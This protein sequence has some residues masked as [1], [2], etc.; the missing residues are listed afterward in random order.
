MGVRVIHKRYRNRALIIVTV[1]IGLLGFCLTG[2]PAW[3]KDR[4]LV[5]A[6]ILLPT[7]YDPAVGADVVSRA[8]L[9]AAYE[10]LIR[11]KPGTTVLEPCLAESYEVSPDSLTYTFTLKKN[12]KF[13][14]G[15]D[16]NAEAVK[17]SIDRLKE[18]NRGPAVYAE[19][20]KE[21]QVLAEDKV[22]LILKAINPMFPQ[23]LPLIYM[24][25][26]TYVK[27]HEENGDW[28]RK[29]LNENL[30]GGTGPY[31]M[32]NF[33]PGEYAILVKNPDYWRGWREKSIDRII[34]RAIKESTTRRLLM[35]K[36]DIHISNRVTVDDLVALEKKSD[37]QIVE[38]PN[39]ACQYIRLNNKK[40][41]FD[42]P[43]IR[44][45]VAYAFDYRAVIEKIMRGRATPLYGPMPK[46]LFAH[47][48]ALPTLNQ[49]K[50]KA[51]KIL[52]DAGYKPGDIQFT[53]MH[54]KEI[55]IA[56]TIGELLQSDLK[57]VGIEMKMQE[58]TWVALLGMIKSPE[59]TP[60]MFD[61]AHGDAPI[62]DSI[63]FLTKQFHSQSTGGK[64]W[65]QHW[66]MNPKVDE[67]LDQAKR[68]AD[69]TQRAG[70]IK[71]AQK[72]IFEDCPQVFMFQKHTMK[73]VHK[74]VKGY[75]LDPL[76]WGQFNFYDMYFE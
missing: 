67:L 23:R 7:S 27:Q 26:P 70:L 51:R 8:F 46:G 64:S 38:A 54:L 58:I 32:E 25:S 75:Q 12:I 50:E 10:G 68:T 71:E 36:G 37:I 41:P 43:R 60:Q 5:V 57:D 13:A 2:G 47:N 31:Y 73:P 56:R 74:S 29:Y 30:A 33:Q 14:D 49:D 4:T 16:F 66:Y 19:D 24:V 69:E 18:I 20:I 22:K 39:F 48:D 42:D 21:V 34:W 1:L 72:I 11:Y 65:N 44:Q 62:D 59:T 40:A 55:P 45:A 3:A 17:F 15:T 9:Y 6:D 63:D 61:G 28:G 53:F 76:S 52:Q 35:E